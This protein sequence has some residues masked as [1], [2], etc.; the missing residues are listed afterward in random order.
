[1][2][3]DRSRSGR[4]SIL[5]GVR[6]P[7]YFTMP[8]ASVL[9]ALALPSDL[10][11]R[12]G[13]QP[14]R[15]SAERNAGQA[16]RRS[17][18]GNTLNLALSRSPQREVLHSSGQ[19]RDAVAR[20]FRAPLAAQR[21]PV[22][23]MSPMPQPRTPEQV[24]RQSADFGTLIELASATILQV[25]SNLDLEILRGIVNSHRTVDWSG[26]DKEREQR[27]R[28][29]LDARKG[30]VEFARENKFKFSAGEVKMN[31]EYWKNEGAR[32]WQ[33]K[34]GVD[35]REAY[36]DLHKHPEDYEL[37]CQQAT[38]MTMRAGSD[39]AK[40][41]EDQG[42]PASDWIPGDWGRIKNTGNGPVA[43][44]EEG[45]NVIYLGDGQF[46]GLSNKKAIRTGDE[47]F[48]QVKEWNGAAA[49]EDWRRR[50]VL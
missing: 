3:R 39:F 20:A 5:P 24:Q 38:A 11:L 31:T 16:A 35:P 1:M 6:Q 17:I 45:E 7:G 26:S 34:K 4:A 14:Q 9:E 37:G 47:W 15:E 2:R 30:I 43:S 40:M 46:W 10:R 27:L 12:H 29:H 18:L 41:V 8:D 50:P 42:V 32:E 48:N 33:P 19:S 22:P 49:I 13:D 21:Q 23:C 44:G 36:Q 28:K 25:S